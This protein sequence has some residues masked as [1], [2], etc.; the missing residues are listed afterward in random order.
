M[1]ESGVYD[2]EEVSSGERLYSDDPEDEPAG[3]F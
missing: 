3:P 2:K 1:V